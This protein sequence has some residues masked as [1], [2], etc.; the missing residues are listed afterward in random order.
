MIAQGDNVG[1]LQFNFS[2]GEVPDAEHETASLQSTRGRLA[3]S[4]S[5][6]IALALANLRLKEALANQSIRDPLTGLFNRRYLEQVLER[7]CRRSA[8]SKRADGDGSRHRPFQA[9]QRH[10]GP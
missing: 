6:Q 1:I 9:V 3:Q 4:L 10:V 2:V 8:R 5:E 7:E